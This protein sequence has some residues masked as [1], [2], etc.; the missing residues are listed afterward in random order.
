MQPGDIDRVLDAWEDALVA[1]RARARV[2]A[3]H[4][5]RVTL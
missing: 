4:A 2:A 1:D 5:H 3:R